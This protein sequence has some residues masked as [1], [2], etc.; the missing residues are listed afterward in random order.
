MPAMK[1][2]SILLVVLGL[3]LILVGI[4]YMPVFHNPASQQS[5]VI[6]TPAILF[7]N[8]DD[9]CDCMVELTRQAE[10]QMVDWPVERRGGVP[11]IR[12][13]YEHHNDLLAKYSIFRA[14]CLVLV[15]QD[16]QVFWRQDYPILGG[17]PFELGELESA[18]QEMINK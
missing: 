11:V 14:P 16:G 5:E 8:L 6:E 12:I 1:Q 2:K 17:E 4:K 3:V 13:P 18:I 10:Q 9:P 7:F 15:A